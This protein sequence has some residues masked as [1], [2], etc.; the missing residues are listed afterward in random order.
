MPGIAFKPMRRMTWEFP[1]FFNIRV[2]H[3]ADSDFIAFSLGHIWGWVE[4]LPPPLVVFSN[5]MVFL[6]YSPRAV[7]F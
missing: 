5:V 7:K 6:T 2:C 1:Q 3:L 4:V